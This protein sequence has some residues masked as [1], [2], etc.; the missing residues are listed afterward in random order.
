M[1]EA[2]STAIMIALVITAIV[3]ILMV[4][5]DINKEIS[6]TIGTKVVIA[7]DTLTVVSHTILN[8]YK[9]SDGNV[10]NYNEIQLFRLRSKHN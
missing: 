6:D 4:N 1:K 5:S 7:N 9:L 8:G 2:V 3:L 10:I